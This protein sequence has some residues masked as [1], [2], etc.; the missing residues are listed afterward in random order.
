MSNLLLLRRR[1]LLGNKKV[2]IHD[3]IVD[4]NTKLWLDGVNN[5]GLD[6][7]H[8]NTLENGWV[9]LSGNCDPTPLGTGNTV[10]DNCVQSDGTDKGRISVPNV[11][12]LDITGDLTIELVYTRLGS[13]V[14]NA[15]ILGRTYTTSYYVNTANNNLTFWI[16]G[17]KAEDKSGQVLNN[18]KWYAQMIHNSTGNL[19]TIYLNNEY[20]AEASV[21]RLQTNTGKLELFGFSGNGT[22][23]NGNI[24]A[25]RIHNKILTNEELKHNF[26]LDYLRFGGYDVG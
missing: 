21:G 9:D 17:Q 13:E 6:V 20:V 1:L 3:Y 12:P 18:K 25:V 23:L 2:S 7:E 11:E 4:S 15:V 8:S 22:K 5:N 24:Y 26:E 19:N 14:T 16:A 10:L